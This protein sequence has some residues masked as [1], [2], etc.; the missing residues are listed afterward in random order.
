MTPLQQYFH[1]I[2]VVLLFFTILQNLNLFFQEI[3]T[4]IWLLHFEVVLSLRL[5][6][7]TPGLAKIPSYFVFL[8]S[9]H[10]EI[11][12]RF[13]VKRWLNQARTSNVKRFASRVTHIRAFWIQWWA[14]NPLTARL[15]GRPALFY[16]QA[17]NILDVLLF[18]QHSG[19]GTPDS[20]ASS[21]VALNTPENRTLIK[22]MLIK[23]AD[24]AN[25]ARPRYL[26]KEWAYRIADEY[27]SQVC[28]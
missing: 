28:R 13:F 1:V 2:M 23:C 11:F 15:T 8:A 6:P 27:F 16:Y 10:F 21:A 18:S 9:Y 26:C 3:F 20:T 12:L 24:I 7:F 19:R 14:D 25:P 5:V 4:E 17:V 22:R